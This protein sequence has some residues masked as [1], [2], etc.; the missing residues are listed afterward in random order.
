MPLLRLAAVLA[1]L[2][3][4]CAATTAVKTPTAHERACGAAFGVLQR[5]AAAGGSRDDVRAR[6]C[7]LLDSFSEHGCL[8]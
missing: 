6:C 3:A 1:V 5:C 7:D 4:C 2:F 8:W